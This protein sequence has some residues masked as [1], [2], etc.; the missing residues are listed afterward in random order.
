[1]YIYVLLCYVYEKCAKKAANNDFVFRL[2]L[3]TFTIGN[4]RRLKA[5]TDLV[6]EGQGLVY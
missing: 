1:M 6:T 2:C 4:S 5:S 3:I